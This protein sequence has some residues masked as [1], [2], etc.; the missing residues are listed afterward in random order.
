M[1]TDLLAL[2]KKQICRCV[3]ETSDGSHRLALPTCPICLGTGRLDR[4][5]EKVIAKNAACRIPTSEEY[6][7][8][9]GAHCR[10]IYQ[11]L[12]HSWRCPACNRTKYELLRWTMLYPR[13]P[14]QHEGW[15]VGLHNHH[16]HRAD[17]VWIEG[18]PHS[19]GWLPRFP[20]TVIC[21]Q[22]NSADA[23]AKRKL[24][25]PATF[26]FSPAEI[27]SFVFATPHGWHLLNYRQA[28]VIYE[29]VS[30]VPPPPQWPP[31][32]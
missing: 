1:N 16:D 15:A 2:P 29:S 26:S 18:K 3:V 12:D 6:F 27:G 5:R 14:R 11:R 17:P 9:D 19:S 8:F 32:L 23:T 22:C 7:A 21:E 20:L 10:Q 25:L 31:I 13:S 28:E 4:D 24:K 30:R